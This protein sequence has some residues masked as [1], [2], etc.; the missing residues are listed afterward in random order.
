MRAL[1][2]V[3]L[4]LAGGDAFRRQAPAVTRLGSPDAVLPHDF[5]QIRGV[6]ERRG[7][8][9][10]VTDRIAEA[11][12]AVDFNARTATRIGRTGGG[13]EEYRLPGRLVPLPGDSVLLIDEGNDRLAV[14]GPDDRIHRTFHARTPELSVGLT[15]R[16]VDSAGRFYTM[17]PDWVLFGMRQPSDSLPI[18]RFAMGAERLE[19]IGWIHPAPQPPP[20]PRR[21]RPRIPMLIFGAGDSWAASPGGRIAIVHAA[22]YRIEWIEPN[23]TRATGPAVAWEPLPVTAADRTAYT[24]DFLATSGIGGKGG[25]GGAP[26]GLSAVPAELQTDAR[27]PEMV[28]NTAF[29]KTRPP[30][31]DA[32]PRIAPDG[33]L[34]VE[35]STPLGAP[36]TW[37]VF[38]ERGRPAARVELPRGRRLV[39][40]GAGAVYLAALDA[41]GL[42]H[43]ERYRPGSV[44]AGPAR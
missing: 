36:S 14:I 38:D 42:E 10:L 43:L 3:V 23:G 22:P 13:P 44:P 28:A 5:S 29:A 40:L 4:V 32:A 34:W 33:R 37:D 35:R 18:V 27:V 17:I 8:R 21:D 26:G 41:D 12:L 25:P 7:G 24:K 30:F 6:V 16:A 2:A 19:R 39:A 20:P 1:I 15:P 31:T 9:L 11:L